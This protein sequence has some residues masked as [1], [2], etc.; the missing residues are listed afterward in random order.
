MIPESKRD[1]LLR[2]ATSQVRKVYEYVPMTEPWSVSQIASEMG[3]NQRV[4]DFAVIH[5]TL[6][7]MVRSGLVKENPKNH[8]QREEV[9][10]TITCPTKEEIMPNTSPSIGVKA[11][12]ALAPEGKA[13]IDALDAIA[14]QLRGLGKLLDA[15]ASEIEEVAIVLAE[16]GANETEEL[17]QLR[18]MRDMLRSTLGG[19]KK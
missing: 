4:M 11:A 12:A 18:A 5:G 10:A 7:S 2:E 19:D 3:R 8:Y 15:A 13:P 9:R 1:R 17:K 6:A 14:Q 16:N